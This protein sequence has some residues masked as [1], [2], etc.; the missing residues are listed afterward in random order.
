MKETGPE[1]SSKLEEDQDNS[2]TGSP[3]RRK[4]KLEVVISAISNAKKLSRMGM[5]RQLGDL[6]ELFVKGESR[7]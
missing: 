5:N 7:L 4:F 6:T 2:V 1:W 3:E